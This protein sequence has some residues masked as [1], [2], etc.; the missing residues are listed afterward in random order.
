MSDITL[1]DVVITHEL[2][3]RAA[4]PADPLAERRALEVIAAVTPQGSGAILHALCRL[5]LRLC[6]GGSCGIN[7][8]EAS[9]E[10]R[11]FRWA[12]I[13][14]LLHPYQGSTAPADHSPCGYVRERGSPQLLSDSARYFEWMQAVDIRA[15]ESL[16]VPLYRE[17][18]EVIGT[19][20][21]VSHDDRSRFDSE[22]LRVLT[23]LG[24]H[25]TAAMRL[26]ESMYQPN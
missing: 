16:I 3:Q 15:V 21:L 5:G 10:H 7:L 2:T 18:H 17:K 4:R 8:L 26:H 9:G 24:S 13:E 20:W 11:Q 6:E 25:A 1:Q 23:L 22:D 19:M 12:V 14:G